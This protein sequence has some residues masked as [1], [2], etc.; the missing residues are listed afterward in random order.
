M[1]GPTPGI[2][3]CLPRG[4]GARYIGQPCGPA[5]QF[6][7]DALQSPPVMD[8]ELPHAFRGMVVEEGYNAGHQLVAPPQ[9]GPGSNP[10]DTFPQPEY[11]Q[12]YQR[13][14]REP[15]VDYLYGYE[16]YRPIPESSYAIPSGMVGAIP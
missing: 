16:A 5:G 11:G 9:Y 2:Q 13:L 4:F 1:H 10:Y 8:S 14:G 12:Y 3:L 15:Y 6:G 7:Y